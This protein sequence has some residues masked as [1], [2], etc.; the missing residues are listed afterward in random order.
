MIVQRTFLISR[1]EAPVLLQAVDHAH[2]TFAGAVDA[3]I[4][5]ACPALV[6]LARNGD[7]DA[8]LA[9]V[10]PDRATAVPLIAYHAPRRAL[11]PP[12][13]CTLHGPLRHQLGKHGGLMPVAGSQDEGHELALTVRTDVDF[14]AEAALT[15]AE[16][17]SVGV[18]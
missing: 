14:G 3:P 13:A 8:M 15:P 17:F 1:R 10:L 2:H 18:A 16:R 9:A 6:A 7:A 4:K 12:A 11:G 5:G